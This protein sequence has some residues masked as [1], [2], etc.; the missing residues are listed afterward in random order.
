M[1]AQNSVNWKYNNKD[2]CFIW[3]KIKNKIKKKVFTKWKGTIRMVKYPI[4]KEN[5]VSTPHRARAG[6]TCRNKKRELV[7][8][9]WGWGGASLVVQ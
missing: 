3:E 2:S 6:I 5:V 1:I 9:I 8:P 7:R 4:A